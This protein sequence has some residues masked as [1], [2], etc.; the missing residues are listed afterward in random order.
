MYPLSARKGSDGSVR[1][2]ESQ[3]VLS[4][5]MYCETLIAAARAALR[6]Q[7]AMPLATISSNGVA[8]NVEG[9]TVL[10]HLLLF[11]FCGVCCFALWFWAS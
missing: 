4:G 5:G 9:L 7:A 2:D 1:G 10:T 6:S 3:A 8:G 11:Y